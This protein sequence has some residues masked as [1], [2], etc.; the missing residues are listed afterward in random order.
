M[1]RIVA[2][3]LGGMLAAPWLSLF[4]MA[5]AGSTAPGPQ[6]IEGGVQ[7]KG[8]ARLRVAGPVG[9]ADQLTW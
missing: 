8:P 3:L 5:W 1:K 9:D 7:N 2:P 4:I 6:M